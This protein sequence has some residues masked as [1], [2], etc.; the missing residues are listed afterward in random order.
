M[1]TVIIRA[2]IH[3]QTLDAEL[4][5]HRT[6]N[7][8]LIIQRRKDIFAVNELMERLRNRNESRNVIQANKVIAKDLSYAVALKGTNFITKSNTSKPDTQTTT[9]S[10]DAPLP[11]DNGNSNEKPFGVM[12]AVFEIRKLSADY[13]FILELGKQLRRP[14]EKTG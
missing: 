5:D 9:Q 8:N 3:Q 7:E 1:E 11:T 10:K 13:P 14:S 4:D 2:L 6:R 12:D